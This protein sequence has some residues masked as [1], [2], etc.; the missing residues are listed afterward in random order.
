MIFLTGQTS[1]QLNFLN[2]FTPS[3]S[4]NRPSYNP[5]NNYNNNNNFNNNNNI[6]NNNMNTIND[7]PDVITINNQPPFNSNREPDVIVGLLLNHCHK[8]WKSKF[9]LF[10]TTCN[11]LSTWQPSLSI[12][13]HCLKVNTYRVKFIKY[14]IFWKKIQANNF[15]KL[16]YV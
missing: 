11:L 14:I 12:Y 9:Q 3:S 15:E 5:P 6:G 4:Y 2:A 8:I 7:N 10:S 13:F 1:A 16:I